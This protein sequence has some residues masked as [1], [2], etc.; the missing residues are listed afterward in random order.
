MPNNNIVGNKI[1]YFRNKKGITQKAL[2]D[3]IGKTESSIQKYECGSTEVPFSVLEKIAK[4][5]DIEILFLLDDEYLESASAYFMEK[6]D[7]KL[8]TLLYDLASLNKQLVVNID[9]NYMQILNTLFSKLNDSGKK[10]A[11]ERLEELIEIPRYTN[12]DYYD[13]ED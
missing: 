13:S 2:A 12:P 10:K 1:R 6:G 3:L 9:A 11:L 8:S 7:T 4:A 5:L